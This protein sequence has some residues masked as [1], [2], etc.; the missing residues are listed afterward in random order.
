VLTLWKRRLS[1]ISRPVTSK[2]CH[3]HFLVPLEYPN[4]LLA[5]LRQALM[6]ALQ[7]GTWFSK[8]LETTMAGFTRPFMRVAQLLKTFVVLSRRR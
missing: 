4:R 8:A 7:S 1:R 6:L 5:A 2:S 3:L